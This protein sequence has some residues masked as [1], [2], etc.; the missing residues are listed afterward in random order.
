MPSFK[1]ELPK[2]G[3]PIRPTP[4]PVQPGKE[5][6]LTGAFIST[7]DGS[8][9][10]AATTTWP[11][12]APGGASV[13]AMGLIDW[14]AGGLR[15]NKRDLQTHEVHAVATGEAAPACDVAGVAAPC[16]VLRTTSQANNRL[17][18]N[19]EWVQSLKGQIEVVYPEPPTIPAATVPYL[20]VAGGLLGVGLLAAVGWTIARRRARSPAGQLLALA[21]R[22]REKLAGADPVLAAPLAPAVEAAVKAVRR[23][24]VDPGSK[25]GQRVAEVLR[26]VELRIEAASAA[27]E[28]Q[29]AD[30]LVREV[31]S[32]L[33]AADEMAPARGRE[34][35]R[36]D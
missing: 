4:V 12:E 27:E 36:G 23:R 15:M 29:A 10:D 5:I 22:V 34:P 2:P 30:E 14:A 7:H 35:P 24:R 6:T 33:E 32:A 9:I 17:M 31:E 13:D 8:T 11:P 1:L 28:Q 20:A 16:L 3:E 25:E 19:D 26:R 21:D 18:T